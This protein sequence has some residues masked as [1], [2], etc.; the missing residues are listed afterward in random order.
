MDVKPKQLPPGGALAG[1]GGSSDYTGALLSTSPQGW[2]TLIGPQSWTPG[3]HSAVCLKSR[4][5]PSQ[6]LS[7]IRSH[8]SAGGGKG[9][10]KGGGGGGWGEGCRCRCGTELKH[11]GE[12]V[13]ESDVEG[14]RGE[15]G[16]ES[17]LHHF[18]ADELTC[19]WFIHPLKPRPLSEP[20][21]QDVN[22]RWQQLLPAST[23][24]TQSE[25]SSYQ[26]FVSWFK[27]VHKSEKKIT[28]LLFF[29]KTDS[30]VCTV[31]QETPSPAALQLFHNNTQT[32]L[33]NNNVFRGKDTNQ[34]K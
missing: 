22:T 4:P 25:S 16:S 23:L 30:S 31:H 8:F 15:A 17:L 21:D 5:N 1:R 29:F 9:G 34:E 27:L 26:P 19:D 28:I 7:Q 12:E 13:T 33:Y 32:L 2:L 14:G 3:P 10:T 20:L 18:R 6:Q 24:Y 11:G